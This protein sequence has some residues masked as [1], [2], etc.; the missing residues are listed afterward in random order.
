MSK[1]SYER[2]EAIGMRLASFKELPTEEE[3]I[4]MMDEIVELRD[5]VQRL[6]SILDFLKGIGFDSSVDF[7]DNK[8]KR[9]LILAI[10]DAK[11]SED[12]PF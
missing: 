8:E 2:L 7:Y 4:S 11:S 10:F 3:V 12:Y 9:R 5:E 6:S 1:L